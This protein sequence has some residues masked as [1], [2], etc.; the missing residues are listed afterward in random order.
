MEAVNELHDNGRAHLDIRLENIC[1]NESEHAVLIDLDRSVN[2]SL[3]NYESYGGYSHM[4]SS[5]GGEWKAQNADCRQLAMMTH[6]ILT[7]RAE[8]YHYIKIDRCT[9]PDLFFYTMFTQGKALR[10][11]YVCSLSFV[12][13]EV[14]IY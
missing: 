2:A 6:Y 5:E 9:Y 10:V 4:Y 14:A 1:F 3:V 11:H 7:G 13:M 8:D 12:V